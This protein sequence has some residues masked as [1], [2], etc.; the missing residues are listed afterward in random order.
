MRFNKPLSTLLIT[1]CLVL[2]FIATSV[3]NEIPQPAAKKAILL[4]TFGTSVPEARESFKLLE[5]KVKE[6]FPG[7]EVRWAYTSNMIRNKLAKEGKVL[8]SPIT[9]LA[10]LQDEGYNKVAVQSVH[11]FPGQE[12]SDLVNIVT[13]MSGF[14]AANHDF[15]FKKL[16]LGAPLL[17]TH[18]DYTEA[19]QALKP[20]IPTGSGSALVIMGHGTEHF[21]FSTYGCLNDILRQSYKNVFLGTVEGYPSL[22]DVKADLA[23]AKVSKV[24]LMPFMNIAGDHA[25]NDLAGDEPDSWKSQLKGKYNV[26][27]NSVGLLD[28]PEIVNLYVK[29]LREAFAQLD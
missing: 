15:G 25:I 29:H 26:S 8:D 16:T 7:V 5:N 24:T 19:A 22:E 17:Y 11:I 4:V 6:T 1:L 18:E 28:N 9:A 3:A 20:Y 13:T 2:S 10:K 27:T 21:G 23:K 12:Y 14:Q